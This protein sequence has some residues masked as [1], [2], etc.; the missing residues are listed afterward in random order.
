MYACLVY[1]ANCQLFFLHNLHNILLKA[2]LICLMINEQIM[3]VHYTSYI[4]IIYYYMR[5]YAL[6]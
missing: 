1:M 4:N 6:L 2:N 5:A 3:D